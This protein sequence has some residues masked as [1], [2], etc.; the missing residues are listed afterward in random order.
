MSAVVPYR[1]NNS[2]LGLW[3]VSWSVDCPR[4]S[5]VVPYRRDN[6]DSGGKTHPWKTRGKCM[7]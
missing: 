1:R 5:G 3:R 7:G 2:D 4:M 6:L